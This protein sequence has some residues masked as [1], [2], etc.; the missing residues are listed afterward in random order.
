MIQCIYKYIFI[1]I[2]LCVIQLTLKQDMYS[3]TLV[4]QLLKI[5]LTITIL[6]E[7]ELLVANMVWGPQLMVEGLLLTLFLGVTQKCSGNHMLYLV[8]NWQEP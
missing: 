8:S 5:N 3:L 2:G 4:K 6:T 7:N 1:I